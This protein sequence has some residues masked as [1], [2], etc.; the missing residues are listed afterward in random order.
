M[1]PYAKTISLHKGDKKIAEEVGN[2]AG[3]MT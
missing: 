3:V 1:R 2:R